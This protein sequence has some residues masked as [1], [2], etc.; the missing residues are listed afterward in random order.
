MKQSQKRRSKVTVNRAIHTDPPVDPS[1]VTVG[2]YIAYLAPKIYRKN[3]APSWPPDAF[4]LV[5]SL[6]QESG[7][8]TKVVSQW[9]P[10]KYENSPSDWAAAISSIGRDW[11]KNAT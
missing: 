5:A 10:S 9:P 1:A 8:Y 7:A 6:L 2:D 3:R 4:A 11:R